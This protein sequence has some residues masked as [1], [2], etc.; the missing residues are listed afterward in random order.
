MKLSKIAWQTYKEVPADAE[1]PSHQLMMRAGL[2]HKSGSGLYSYL[3]F[4]LKVL[5]KIENIVREELDKVGCQEITMAVVTPGELWQKSGRWDKMEGLMVQFKDKGGRDLCL[6]P[7][8]EEAI[9][10]I[11][12]KLVKSYKNLPI[13]LYQINTKF[14]DEIRPRFGLM[15]AR[16]FTMKDAYS[17]HEDQ[18]SLEKV[19]DELFEVYESIFKRIGFEFS[20]VE[21]DGGAMASADSKTHEFQVIA[22][23]GEDEIVYV[24]GEYAANI[25]KAM[26]KRADL[27]FVSSTDELKDIETPNMAT[28][29]DV[30]HFLGRP[31]CQSL[32]SLVYISIIDDEATPVLVLLLGDDQLNDLKLKN[33]LGSH[34]LRPATDGELT[35]LGFVKGFIGPFGLKK[36]VKVFFDSA[37]DKDSN[38]VVGAM[39]ENWHKENFKPGRD[40][41]GLKFLDL[42]L[43]KEGDLHPESGKP[44][45]IKRGIEVGHIFHLGDKY[46]ESMGISILDKNGKA[47]HPL[48]GCYGLG[49][50]RVAAAA[51]E[52]SHDEKG[53]IWPKAISPF[54]VH[55]LSI[56][57]SDETKA[58][59]DEIY[60]ELL[61][62]EFEVLYDDRKVGPGFKFKDADLLGCPIQ[63]VLG[64][65]VYKETGNVKIINRATGDEKE[66]K[67]A[68]LLNEV[69]ALWNQI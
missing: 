40:F 15:R 37:V 34:E 3:P 46:T 66:V 68:D 63:V 62:S 23:N 24:E 54:Q 25:E 61:A 49:I 29:E 38:Y 26:T 14:R 55:Y 44:V 53:I 8:N 12:S 16:E 43:A 18:A 33:A 1:I 39:K 48:M 60:E 64:E 22:E 20:A 7:T 2:I 5:R 28:I 57:K 10:D 50:T 11:F 69:K 35:N 30:C 36:E 13:T 52:Q 31:Q 59:A 56:A 32:K 19:Y 4:G 47:M 9:T 51:I 42:R 58:K 67:P 65:R 27:D 21:A 45:K 41:S 17:F 6:S